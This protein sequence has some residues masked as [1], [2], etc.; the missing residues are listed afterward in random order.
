MSGKDC[1]ARLR[2]LD[3]GVR[4]ILS[5]G[6]IND[7]VVINFH[8]YGFRDVITKPYRIDELGR[9]LNRVLLD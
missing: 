7:P 9:I 4:A 2:E 5:S 3:P 6:Y 1:V 8:D